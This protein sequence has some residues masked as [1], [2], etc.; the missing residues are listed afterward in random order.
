MIPWV[1]DPCNG[2]DRAW[3]VMGVIVSDSS[4]FQCVDLPVKALVLDTLHE[5]TQSGFSVRLCYLP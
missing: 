3:L 4:A 5:F 1:Y 2:F